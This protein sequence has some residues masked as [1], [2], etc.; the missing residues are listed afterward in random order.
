M[1][2]SVEKISWSPKIRQSKIRQLYQNDALGAVDEI[3]VEDVGLALGEHVPAPGQLGARVRLAVDVVAVAPHRAVREEHGA[4]GVH[5][6]VI[7]VD[8]GGPLDLVDQDL[9]GPGGVD[10]A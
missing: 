2:L 4:V 6:D 8:H 9:D 5:H 3:I 1:K 10:R 7:H